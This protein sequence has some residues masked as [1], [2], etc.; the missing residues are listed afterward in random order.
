ML[1]LVQ[2]GRDFPAQAGGLSVLA[3]SGAVNERIWDLA[4]IK[5]HSSAVYMD[6]SG[7]IR[8]TQYWQYRSYKFKSKRGEYNKVNGP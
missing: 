5:L 6:S 7:Q 1:S 4:P 3:N 8:S 2:V